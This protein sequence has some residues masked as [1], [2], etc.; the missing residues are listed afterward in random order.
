MKKKEKINTYSKDVNDQEVLKIVVEDGE[1]K[2]FNLLRTNNFDEKS[3]E[4]IT[5]QNKFFTVH[6][7]QNLIKDLEKPGYPYK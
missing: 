2:E 6:Y 1:I 3:Y 7:L 4:H 5:N